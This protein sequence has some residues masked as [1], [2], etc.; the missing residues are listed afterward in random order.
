MRPLVA[1]QE[2]TAL[3]EAMA[4]QLG[5]G[6]SWVGDRAAAEEAEEAEERRSP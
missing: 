5:A 6:A 4:Q 1:G 2:A 3:L